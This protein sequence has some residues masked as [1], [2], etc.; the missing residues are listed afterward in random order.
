MHYFIS[1]AWKRGATAA[2]AANGLACVAQ[3][4]DQRSGPLIPPYELLLRP[5]G[6]GLEKLRR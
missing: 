1:R 6:N 3:K 5:W 2:V 4:D